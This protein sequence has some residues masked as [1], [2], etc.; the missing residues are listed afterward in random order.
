MKKCIL[1][2]LIAGFAGLAYADIQA[3]PG[4]RLEPGRK[5]SRAFANIVYGVTEIPN[6]WNREMTFG[7][8]QGAFAQ[9]VVRGTFRGVCRLGYGAYELVTFPFPTYKGSYRPP[10]NNLEYDPN[11]GFSEFP[12]PV[13][14]QSASP[15]SRLTPSGW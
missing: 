8:A 11:H 9:A 14:F 4:A 1:I 10:Y 12:P 6:T 13:G 5:L 7:N 2:A 15:Y 3:P